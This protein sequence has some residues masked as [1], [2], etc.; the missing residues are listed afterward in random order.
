MGRRLALALRGDKIDVVVKSG[1]S[2]RQNTTQ[3]GFLGT[4][5]FIQAWP[6]ATSKL[7][8]CW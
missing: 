7:L 8:T 4:Q 3:A 2:G 1:D 5:D 6:Q